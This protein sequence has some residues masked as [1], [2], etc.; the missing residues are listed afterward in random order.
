MRIGQTIVVHAMSASEL[1]DLNEVV[2]DRAPERPGEDDFV[3]TTSIEKL[4]DS[5]RDGERRLHMQAFDY[6]HSLHDG[7]TKPLFS[8]LTPAGLAPFKNNSLLL[9]IHSDQVLVRFCGSELRPVL[10]GAPAPGDDLASLGSSAF[11]KALIDRFSNA[12]HRQEVAEFEFVDDPVDCRGIMLPLGSRGG[13]IDFVLLVVNHGPREA[14][15]EATPSVQEEEAPETSEELARLEGLADVCAENGRSVV[16]PD[17]GT[18]EGLYHAL[19]KT[20]AFHIDASKN[21]EAYKALLKSR[22]LRQQ[23]RAPFTPA[24]KLTFGKGY[25]KTRLTEYAAAL[26]FAARSEVG[27]EEFVAFL[28]AQP[29]GIKGCVL[30]E[31]DI[32][33]GRSGQDQ[34]ALFDK[35]RKIEPK[36]PEALEIEG[37]FG[38]VLVRRGTDGS[39]EFL[40]P[41]EVPEQ[42]LL[43]ALGQV[44]KGEE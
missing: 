1:N 11:A 30:A 26:S 16:H 34:E 12:A 3:L 36:A 7:A 18:R 22:G 21:P 42:Q 19:A 41:V 5:T 27:P 38:F 20:Y 25:D 33:H 15:E 13:N 8:D 9:E 4:G 44:T 23:A 24:L 43:K 6:W 35:A 40:G 37:E 29:G 31:R 10:D 32:R 17:L 28:Q 39:S 2:P 14:L